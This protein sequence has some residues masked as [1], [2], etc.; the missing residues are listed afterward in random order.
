MWESEMRLSAAGS[1]LPVNTNDAGMLKYA[2]TTRQE[3]DP[4]AGFQFD[5]FHSCCNALRKSVPPPERKNS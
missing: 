1:R 5:D 3:L 4:D 2:G